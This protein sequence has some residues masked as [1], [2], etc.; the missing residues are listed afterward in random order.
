MKI[1]FINP[2]FPQLKVLHPVK[3]LMQENRSLT[4]VKIEK[5]QEQLGFDFRSSFLVEKENPISV[6][7]LSLASFLEKK[8]YKCNY[9]QQSLYSSKRWKKTLKKIAKHYEVICISSFTFNFPLAVHEIVKPLKRLNKNILLIGG[10]Y[11]MSFCDEESISK[12]FDIIVR[13][14]G[15]KTLWEVVKCI[16]NSKEDKLA[17]IPNISYK[18][19]NRIRRNKR[20]LYSL[21]LERLPS[22]AYHLLPRQLRKDPYLC[23]FTSRGCPYKCKYCAEGNFWQNFRRKSINKIVE[24]V[25]VFLSQCKTRVIF[26]GDSTF[27][28]DEKYALTILRVLRK[29]FPDVYFAANMR[30]SLMNSFV[31]KEFFKNNLRIIFAGIESADPL[32]LKAVKRNETPRSMLQGIINCSNFPFIVNLSYIVGLPGEN[33][34]SI[35]TTKRFID[36]TYKY[37]TT[38]NL[39]STVRVFV[40]YP[41]TPIF[42]QPNL[43]GLKILHKNWE[44]YHR[45]TKPVF[46]L[47]RFKRIKIWEAFIDLWKFVL[48]KEKEQLQ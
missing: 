43:F 25:S 45:Y 9:F 34:V 10:G 3:T 46:K 24:D 39:F 11:H 8:G 28:L 23:L 12:G 40:P 5:I 21:D 7:L 42:E 31:V 18:F 22:P 48:K 19:N 44:E 2:R 20:C 37:F 16:E 14:E 36:Q 32:I 13:G 17:K 26:F 15:E 41:G 1:A 47:N 4:K 33:K 27:N 29:E 35:N 30:V 38:P 6:A